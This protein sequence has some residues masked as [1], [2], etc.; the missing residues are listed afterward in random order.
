MKRIVWGVLA[1][2]L[3]SS[4][5]LAQAV[6]ES[7]PHFELGL[8]LTLGTDLGDLLESE[9]GD[10]SGFTNF[11]QLD[12]GVDIPMGQTPFGVVPRLRALVSRAETP[13]LLAGVN[14][15][16]VTYV[17]LPGVSFRFW[18]GKVERKG[19]VSLDVAKVAPG[20]DF[21]FL[22]DIEGDG[23]STGVSGGFRVGKDLLIE[24]GIHQVPVKFG[25]VED[26]DFGGFSVLIKRRF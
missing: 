26:I 7:K 15:T 12:G 8:G 10:V 13:T 3:I 17:M 18:L 14:N 9:Y 16:K 11:L 5:G 2:F 25:P 23:M 22:E 19:Y 4:A 6:P 21:S 1:V 24:A 20:S